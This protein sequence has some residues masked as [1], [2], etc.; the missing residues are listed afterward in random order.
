MFSKK[1]QAVAA[2]AV[3]NPPN[4]AAKR[5]R[6]LTTK[7]QQLGNISYNLSAQLICGLLVAQRNEKEES[8]KQRALT[9]AVR[10][11]QHQEEINGFYKRK[12]GNIYPLPVF[13]ISNLP[14]KHLAGM[15][16]ISSPSRKTTTMNCKQ[17]VMVCQIK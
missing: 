6:T 14:L 11:E 1:T 13:L 4:A 15:M 17:W 3:K 12:Q 7:Q 10:S 5:Q 8:T 2:G 9:N 16:M